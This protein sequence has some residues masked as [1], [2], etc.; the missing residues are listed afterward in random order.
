MVCDY[1]TRYPE[2]VALR[3]V[4]APHIAVELVKIFSR[5][6]VPEEVL[7]DQG[8]NF[9]SQLL[10]EVYRFLHIKLIR[11]TPYH[12]QTDGLVERFNQTLKA[13]LRKTTLSGERS[14]DKL[15]PYVI[16]SY[17][18]VPQAS[19]GF[20]PSIRAALWPQSARAIGRFAGDVGTADEGRGERHHLHARNEGQAWFNG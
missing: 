20:S 15:L 18:E 4:E 14:W 6:G 9:M 19:T 10:T 8:A 11:T 2:A 5:V 1:A 16:F 3:S 7:T 13:M 12:P 17:R